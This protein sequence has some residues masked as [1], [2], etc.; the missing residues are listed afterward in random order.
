ML[1]RASWIPPDAKSG[2]LEGPAKYFLPILN[3]FP[4]CYSFV[5]ALSL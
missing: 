5:Q 4:A 3:P 1:F 2:W